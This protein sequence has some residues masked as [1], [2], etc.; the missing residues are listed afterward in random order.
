MI[1]SRP[2]TQDHDFPGTMTVALQG[3]VVIV[4]D[5]PGTIGKV[6]PVCEFLELRVEVV[7]AGVDLTQALRE[8]RPMA[9]ISDVDGEEQDGFHTM[10]VIARYNRD[11][12]IM[13]LTGGDSVLMGAADAVQDMWGLTSVT[14]TSGFPMAGQLV[15]FLFGAGRRTGGMRLVPI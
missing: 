8:H 15:A 11:L 9:V 14:R 4:S 7:S 2:L 3:V 12:P 10:K 13:L 5:D 1:A 6:A